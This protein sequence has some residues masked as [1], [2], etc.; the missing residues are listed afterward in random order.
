MRFSFNVGGVILRHI[1]D[2]YAG[3]GGLSEAF[4]D[5]WSVLR[6]DSNILL[7]DV[8]NMFIADINR[9]DIHE[10]NGLE[11]TQSIDLVVG[12]PPCLEF[13]NGYNAPKIRARRAGESYYPHEGMKN[14]KRFLHFVNTIKPKYWLMENVIGS[15]EYISDLEHNGKKLGKPRQIIGSHCFW[16]NFPIMDAADYVRVRKDNKSSGTDPLSVQKRGL[17]PLS[18]SQALKKAIESQVSILEYC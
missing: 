11:A 12:G 13:S 2:L 15:I 3:L 16:G 14:V 9:L 5:D 10:A 17:V 6:I 8:P 1:L 18:I 7:T 4:L